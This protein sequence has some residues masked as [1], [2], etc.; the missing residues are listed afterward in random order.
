MRERRV[1]RER[2]GEESFLNEV[3]MAGYLGFMQMSISKS[4]AEM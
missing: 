2:E 3:N 1:K 4:M